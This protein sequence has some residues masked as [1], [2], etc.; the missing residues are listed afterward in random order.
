MCRRGVYRRFSQ[1]DWDA[2]YDAT[3][4]HAD[5]QR[6]LGELLRADVWGAIRVADTAVNTQCANTKKL[7]PFGHTRRGL[8]LPYACSVVCVSVCVCVCVCVC[9]CVCACACACAR[10]RARVRV[11]VRVSVRVCVCRPHLA[12]HTGAVRPFC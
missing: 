9:M 5:T 12:R 10:A 6:R 7:G 4:T 3:K 11:R 8:L 1:C 2:A